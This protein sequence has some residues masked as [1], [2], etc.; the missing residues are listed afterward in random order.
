MKVGEGFLL[1]DQDFFECCARLCLIYANLFEALNDGRVFTEAIFIMKES[2]RIPYGLAGLLL[3][4][5]LAF[6]LFSSSPIRDR[7]PDVRR[8]GQSFRDEFGN[9]IFF[10]LGPIPVLIGLIGLAGWLV[11]TSKRTRE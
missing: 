6:M 1:L 8:Q 2:R 9:S 11:P 5:C 3:V 7:E 10:G 4:G